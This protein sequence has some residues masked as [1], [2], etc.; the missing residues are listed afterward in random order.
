MV[1]TCEKKNSIR[2]RMVLVQLT[3]EKNKRTANEK[4]FID[5]VRGD[6]Q[7]FGVAE[8][9]DVETGEPAWRHLEKEN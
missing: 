7:A 5:A 6:M 8:Q 2:R 3:G 9:E 1:W 4:R